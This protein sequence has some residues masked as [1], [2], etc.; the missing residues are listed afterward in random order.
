MPYLSKSQRKAEAV[1]ARVAERPLSK[2]ELATW[3]DVSER[4]LEIEIA[5]GRLRA[6]RLGRKVR[7]KP[8]DI[9]RW[10]DRN[11]TMSEEASV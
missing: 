11:A 8:K 5:E 1:Q 10:M 2:T 4:F 9:E 6:V 3:L 7:F